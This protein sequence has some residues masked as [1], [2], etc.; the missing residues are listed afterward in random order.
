MMDILTNYTFADLVIFCG[1]AFAAFQG[2]IK[3]AQSINDHF[4]LFMT[5]RLSKKLED[6]EIKKLRAELIERVGIIEKQLAVLLESDKSRIKGEILR[7]H[8]ECM[9]NGQ[10]DHRTYEYLHQQYA[11]Y[12]QEGGNSFVDGLMED[13]DHLKKI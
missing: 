11:A 12:K 2:I 1:V 4:Q 13:I 10:I 7:Y 8:Q 3:G 9:K 5:K 6:S